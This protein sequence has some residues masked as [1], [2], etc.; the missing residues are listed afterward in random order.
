[1][2][3]YKKKVDTQLLV[4]I[5]GVVITIFA[6]MFEKKIKAKDDEDVEN[7]VSRDD[8]SAWLSSMV[9]EIERKSR[10]SQEQ[11]DA[12]MNGRVVEPPMPLREAIAK[13]TP[14]RRMNGRVVEPPMP[15]REAIAKPTPERRKVRNNSKKA[16]KQEIA[17]LPEE[18]IRVTKD[19]KPQ[20]RCVDNKRTIAR[21]NELRRAVIWS[22]IMPPKYKEY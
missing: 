17:I 18:G 1:M 16:R 14:E 20:K 22:E 15:L 10:N 13:P 7:D 2:Q 12:M 9:N 21:R 3:N 11:V 5:I 6:P 19:E 8:M 4:I